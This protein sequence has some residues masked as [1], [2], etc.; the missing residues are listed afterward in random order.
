MAD[1]QDDDFIYV[2]PDKR[3]V[4]GKVEWSTDGLPIPLKRGEEVEE[5]EAGENVAHKD[6]RRSRRARYYPW[7]SYRTMKR[8]YRLEG[9]TK[10]A[11]GQGP[12]DTVLEKA[13]KEPYWD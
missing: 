7:G 5:Q 6:R 4:I 13:I 1:Y 2:D 3:V 10:D 9:K 11:L 12:L 8:L